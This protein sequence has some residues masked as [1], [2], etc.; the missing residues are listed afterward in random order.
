VFRDGHKGGQFGEPDAGHSSQI[1]TKLL[2]ISAVIEKAISRRRLQPPL[3][4]YSGG[5]LKQFGDALAADVAL[6]LQEGTIL[7]RQY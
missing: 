4:E 6:W 1:P 7:A 3:L 2:G 5:S